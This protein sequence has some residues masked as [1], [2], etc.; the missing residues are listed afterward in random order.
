MLVLSRRPGQKV[1]FPRL[2]ITIEVLGSKGSSVRLGINAPSDIS[3]LRDEVV[4]QSA[5]FDNSDSTPIQRSQPSCHQ[6]STSV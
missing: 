2:G 5:R 3:I 6:S 1:V 4:D